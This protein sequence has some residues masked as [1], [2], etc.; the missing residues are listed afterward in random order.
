MEQIS[1]KFEEFNS[2]V[3]RSSKSKKTQLDHSNYTSKYDSGFKSKVSSSQADDLRLDN[4][5]T[6]T[7]D[8]VNTIQISSAVKR[9]KNQE[10]ETTEQ[11]A[12]ILEF[13]PFNGCSC[14]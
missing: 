6:I 9:L 5:D 7:V 11:E 3:L 10:R 8:H 12:Q 2:S 1:E 4:Q 14:D 13:L